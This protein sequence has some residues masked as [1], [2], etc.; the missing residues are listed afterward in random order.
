VEDSKYLIHALTIKNSYDGYGVGIN[1]ELLYETVDSG[2]DG[3]RYVVAVYTYGCHDVHYAYCCHGSSYLFGCVGLRNKQYCIFNKQ[4]SKEEYE[5]LVPRIIEQMNTMPYK[6]ARGR[7]YGYGEFFPQEISPFAYN[8]TIAQEYVPLNETI[9]RDA[10]F[11]WKALEQKDYAITLSAV[12]LPDH[13]KDVR[14]D[15]LTQTIG[16]AHGGMCEHQCTT[17][18]KIVPAELQFYR[19]YNITLPRLC[20]NCRHYGRVA[21][22]NPFRLWERSCD[23]NHKDGYT[24]VSSHF[25]GENACPNVFKTAYA[26]ERPE[27]V[28]CEQCYQAE[29]S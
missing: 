25:H 16:C 23:C 28:Y 19:K 15:I 26:P 24:N 10:G 4:Y 6:D 2:I 20:S 9:A 7:T 14:D 5:K 12:D 1:A 11:S 27:I 22:R 18:F 3:A 13:I 29:V 21:Q 8:E 17:A